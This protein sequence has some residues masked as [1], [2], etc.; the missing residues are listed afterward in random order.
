MLALALLSSALALRAPAQE[1]PIL[2]GERHTLPNGL[3]VVLREDHSTPLV[4]VDVRY[5]VGSRDEKPGKTGFAHLFEHYMFEGSAHAPESPLASI[6]NMGGEVNADTTQDRTNYYEIVPSEKLEEILRLEADRMGFLNIDR[7]SLDKQRGIVENEK[8]LRE[9]QPYAAGY[10]ES[11]ALVFDA[12]HPYRQPILGSMTDLEEAKIEDVRRFHA[13]YYTPNNAILVVT[14]DQDNAKT[15]ELV[16]KW[17]G[18]LKRGPKPLRTKLPDSPPLGAP[19]REEIVDEKASRTMLLMAFRIPGK[20][21]PDWLETSI[22]AEILG[23]GGNRIYRTVNKEDDLV[24]EIAVWLGDLQGQDVLFIRA[25]LRDGVSSRQVEDRIRVALAEFSLLGPTDAEMRRVKAARR[26]R[27][28]DAMQTADGL[29]ARLAEGQ[30]LSDDPAAVVTSL[31]AMGA[32]GKDAPR[33]AAY[34]YLMK[35][36]PA[37]VTVKPKPPVEK[38]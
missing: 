27:A 14:G 37:T 29:A 13:A 21:K 16:K 26:R 1:L 28:L 23:D 3:V 38:P 2:S 17:F 7:K 19:R 25:F 18:P 15:Y 12:G 6:S 36:E 30:A 32:M 20:D 9:N 11:P 33:E 35:A 31:K 22:A 34:R 10:A 24:D 8:R 5:G 4:A